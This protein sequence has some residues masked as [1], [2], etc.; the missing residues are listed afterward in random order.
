MI[1]HNIFE[2]VDDRCGRL[3]VLKC[4]STK[5]GRGQFSGTNGILFPKFM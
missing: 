4:G 5:E 2:G 1:K 3:P